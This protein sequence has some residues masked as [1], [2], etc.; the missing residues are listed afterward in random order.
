M[1]ALGI[2][3]G[4]E[5]EHMRGTKLHAEA[6]GFTV[7]GDDGNASFCHENSALN[8]FNDPRNSCD[9]AFLAELWM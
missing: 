5:S 7:L 3:S 9:Y 4:R 6:T 2:E 1:I 8:L